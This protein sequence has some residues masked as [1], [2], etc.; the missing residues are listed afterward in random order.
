ML[1]FCKV[2]GSIPRI[3]VAPWEIYPTL[4]KLFVMGGFLFLKKL[5]L[6]Y[7]AHGKR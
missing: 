4:G 5:F 3:K 2:R 7:Q 1:V 6:R